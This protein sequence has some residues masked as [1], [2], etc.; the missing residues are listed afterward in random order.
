MLESANGEIIMVI[1]LTTLAHR[2]QRI[3]WDTRLE[4]QRHL[5]TCIHQWQ[6]SRW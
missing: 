3:I 2:Q 1:M 4:I 6:V 5:G